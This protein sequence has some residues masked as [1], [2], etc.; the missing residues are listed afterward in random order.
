MVRDLAIAFAEYFHEFFLA[1]VPCLI[2][3]VN[4]GAAQ[5]VKFA[6][7]D[8]GQQDQ[9]ALVAGAL[10]GVEAPRRT[11]CVRRPVHFRDDA[12]VS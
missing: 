10:V 7:G 4:P 8:A 12:A 1:Q 11:R 5:L 2:D 9:V 3:S 6:L